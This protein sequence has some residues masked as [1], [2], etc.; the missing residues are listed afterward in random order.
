M[1]LYSSWMVASGGWEAAGWERSGWQSKAG[2]SEFLP[3]STASAPTLT[4]VSHEHG[5]APIMACAAA[6]LLAPSLIAY[7]ARAARAGRRLMRLPARC[8][9]YLYSFIAY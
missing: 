7:E 6:I 9:R 1:A 2:R 4:N 8:M 5:G 3:S